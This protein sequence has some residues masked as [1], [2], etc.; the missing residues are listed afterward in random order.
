[1]VILILVALLVAGLPTVPAFAADRGSQA[2]DLL[3]YGVSCTPDGAFSADG[4][5]GKTGKDTGSVVVTINFVGIC[6]DGGVLTLAYTQSAD[7]SSLPNPNAKA[8]GKSKGRP[9]GYGW[10]VNDGMATVPE[11]GPV[12]WS[13]THIKVTL[14]NKWG[15]VVKETDL[16]LPYS[17]F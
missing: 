11:L 5:A 7:L 3:I 2:D 15:S 13:A 16:P 10:S 14:T 6:P 12:N 9:S 8:N 1:M 4:F 17:P